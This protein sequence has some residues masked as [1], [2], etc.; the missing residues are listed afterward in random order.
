VEVLH[1]YLSLS[2]SLSR[3]ASISISS[4]DEVLQV[5]GLY[6]LRP[7]RVWNVVVPVPPSADAAIVAMTV[8]DTVMHVF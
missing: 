4:R 6:M 2:L 8:T 5:Q 1:I 7:F 3:A